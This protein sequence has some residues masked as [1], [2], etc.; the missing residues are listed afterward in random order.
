[1]N[2]GCHFRF[3]FNPWL[4]NQPFE[5]SAIKPVS[6]KVEVENP[7]LTKFS[8]WADWWLGG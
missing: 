3:G 1:L 5:F 4:N 6:E 8:V 2:G 7:W